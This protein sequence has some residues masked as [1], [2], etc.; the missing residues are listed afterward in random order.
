MR[1]SGPLSTYAQ[2]CQL[3]HKRRVTSGMEEEDLATVASS[4]GPDRRSLRG[5]RQRC[6]PTA[7]QRTCPERT[8]L[9]HNPARCSSL[10]GHPRRRRLAARAIRTSSRSRGGRSATSAPSCV[11]KRAP[12]GRPFWHVSD[13]ST[14]ILTRRTE[15]HLADVAQSLQFARARPARHG[16]MPPIWRANV[17][18]FL[19]WVSTRIHGRR[20]RRTPGLAG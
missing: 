20:R 18:R 3:A 16:P 13:G 6:R 10:R 19:R 5:H 4:L 8:S 12:G 9:S 1:G 2:L 7:C 11:C 15:I 14:R 17:S